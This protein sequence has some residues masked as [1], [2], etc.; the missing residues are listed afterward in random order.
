MINLSTVNN[1]FPNVMLTSLFE[2]RSA[3]TAN[4]ARAKVMTA[5]RNRRETPTESMN[6]PATTVLNVEVT[7]NAVITQGRS[8][9][10]PK[11]PAMSGRAAAIPSAWNEERAAV[12]KTAIE[13]GSSSRE[14]TLVGP[15]DTP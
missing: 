10:S 4:P 14:R 2:D 7:R 11:A 5:I 12:A 3:P 8:E 13:I 15:L 9:T 1:I 6:G